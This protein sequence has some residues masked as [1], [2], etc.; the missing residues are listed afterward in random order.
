MVQGQNDNEE[1]SSVGSDKGEQTAEEDSTSLGGSKMRRR[2]KKRR[3]DKVSLQSKENFFT[4]FFIIAAC[5]EAYFAYAYTISS[6]AASS[7][8]VFLAELNTT[9][10]YQRFYGT[11]M[12]SL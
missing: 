10:N 3:L 4:P 9:A 5:F 2:S 6:S 1:A 7:I 11:A 8:S 12:N